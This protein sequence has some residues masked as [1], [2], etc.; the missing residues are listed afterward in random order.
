MSGIQFSGLVSGIDTQGIIDKL[1]AIESRPITLLMQRRGTIQSQSDAFKNI[2]TKL[3][4]LEDK[5]F[6]LT[7]LSTVKAKTATSSN[8]AKLTVSA[9]AD[10][11]VDSFDVEIVKLASASLARTKTAAGYGNTI[12]GIGKTITNA[13]SGA[14]LLGTLN[15]GNRFSEAVTNGTFY[16]NGKEVNIDITTDTISSVLTKIQ[17]A[18][19]LDPSPVTGTYSDATG[20]IQLTSASSITLS[21]GTSNFLSVMNLDTSPTGTTRTSTGPISVAHLDQKL[22]DAKTNLSQA[23]AAS[24]TIKINN[25]SITYNKDNDTL[26]DII[27]RINSSGAGVLASYDTDNDQFVLTSTTLGNNAITLDDSNFAGVGLLESLGIAISTGDVSA[28]TLGNNA[29]YKIGTSTYYAT[30]NTITNPAGKTGVTLNLLGTTTPDKINVKIEQNTQSTIDSVK[31]FIDQYN[32]LV[33]Y[34]DELTK[35]DSITKKAGI[36]IGDYTVRSVR[37]GLLNKLMGTVTNL[38]YGSPTTGNLTELGIS[39]GAIGSAPGT[40]KHLEVNE[41]KLGDAIR[42]NPDRVSQIFGAIE[43]KVYDTTTNSYVYTYST[44]KGIFTAVKDYLNGMGSA[45]GVFASKQDTAKNMIA[46]IDKR[47]DDLN[48]RLETKRKYLEDKFTAMEK[49]LFKSQSQQN[50]LSSLVSMTSGLQSGSNK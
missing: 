44:D 33:D 21:S 24:G 43:N 16:V 35:Y 20:K 1:L 27:S 9:T 41:V 36:L 25:V 39:T 32:S 37:T 6:E 4:A 29:E 45:T 26:N 30:S 38:K 23:I 48:N 42:A 12:G 40:T 5:A 46:D 47:V 11:N 10:T 34:I 7:K 2:N 28:Q 18:T 13:E 17:T 14:T 15:T 3:S 31:S 49:A 22:S 19:A 8:T 50:A